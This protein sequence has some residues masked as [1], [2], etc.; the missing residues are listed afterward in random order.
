MERCQG[1]CD[2]FGLCGGGMGSNKFWEHG[3]ARLQRNQRLPLQDDAAGA[4]AAGAALEAA[5]ART[6]QPCRSP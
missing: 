2:Y 3:H 6:N 5:P 1:S 4:G